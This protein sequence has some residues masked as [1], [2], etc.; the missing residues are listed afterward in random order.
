MLCAILFMKR[1][2]ILIILTTI[3]SCQPN[4]KD[5]SDNAK[6]DTITAIDEINSIETTNT[7]YK[8]EILDLFIKVPKAETSFHFNTDIDKFDTTQLVF[9]PDT[10]IDKMNPK[11]VYSYEFGNELEMKSIRQFRDAYSTRDIVKIGF[12]R[13]LPI[14]SDTYDIL[15]A[16]VLDS[17]IGHGYQRLEWQVLAFDKDG[18]QISAI[19]RLHELYTSKDTLTGLWW[20]ASDD[21]PNYETWVKNMQ[22]KFNMTLQSEEIPRQLKGQVK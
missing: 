15:T 6:A 3:L 18:L 20:Y 10:I 11:S 5:I 21:N 17:K 1:T 19:D 7:N 13:L 22:G 12:Y 2:T 8:S 16:F 14:S 9:L 4:K